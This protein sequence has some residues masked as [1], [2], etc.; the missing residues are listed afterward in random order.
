MMA[1]S[2]EIINPERLAEDFSTGLLQLSEIHV[3]RWRNE[4]YLLLDGVFS[5]TSIQAALED[6]KHI[7]MS[8]KDA[9]EFEVGDGKTFPTSYSGLDTLTLDSGFVNAITQL[10]GVCDIRM[11]Q[12]E[13]WKKVALTAENGKDNTFSNQDQRMHM[14]F[15][16]HTLVHP[17]LWDSPEAVAVIIYLSE[18]KECG[19]AT[20]VVPKQS[21][22]ENGDELYQWP[23]FN[24][25][26]IGEIPWKNDRAS[27]EAYL[28]EHHP[29][30]A[31]FREKLYAREKEI[32]Y[33]PGTV[34]FYR[35]DLWHR[36]T[37]LLAGAER[38]VQN[39]V[40]KKAQCDWV[41]NW[42]RGTAYSMYSRDQ[43]VEKMIARMSVQ[44][45]SCLGFP[46]PGS[47]YWTEQTVEAVQRRYGVFGMDI[48]P[49][50]EG[51]AHTKSSTIL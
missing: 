43:Y 45:R 30:V 9:E 39:L 47:A 3:S 29:E 50:A 23:Y 2:T 38:F 36:G 32:T 48:T 33:S 17:P 51:L 13:T 25:P 15:P 34:L 40:F 44:Q 20:R 49:Y 18:G 7:Q 6:I 28:H 26:G 5:S 41:N 24:M 1:E 46:P 22:G 12:A 10:L 11:S 37:P 31:S 14:D 19:G 8:K 42:N 27:V 4:G 35:H 16:N 21:Y